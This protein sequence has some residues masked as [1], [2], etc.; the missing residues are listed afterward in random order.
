MLPSTSSDRI[1][2]SRISSSVILPAPGMS[3]SITN[4]GIAKAGYHLRRG[5][6]VG[7]SQTEP[8]ARRVAAAPARTISP[9]EAAR[10]VASDMWLDYGSGLGQPDLFDQALAA[11]ICELSNVK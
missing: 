9:D 11:R 8:V 10:L 4:S 5:A 3:R 1:E 7:A 2:T 6:R